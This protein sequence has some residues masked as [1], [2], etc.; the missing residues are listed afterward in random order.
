MTEAMDDTQKDRLFRYAFWGAALLYVWV[1]AM[2]WIGPE[3]GLS[4]TTYFLVGI[5]PAIIGVVLLAAAM[6]LYMDLHKDD[7]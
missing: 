3:W 4:G 5:L 1:L 7:S 6:G 2:L